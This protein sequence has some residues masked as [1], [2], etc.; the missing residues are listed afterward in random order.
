MK[1]RRIVVTGMGVVS[2]FGND[3]DSFYNDLLDGKSGVKKITEFD[4]EE[5]CCDLCTC[6]VG[7]VSTKPGLTMNNQ[8]E[9]GQYIAL[10]GLVPVK[11]IGPIKKSDFIVPTAN[12]LARAGKPEE[13]AHKIGV[14]NETNDSDDV[15]LVKCIIK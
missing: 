3:V 7:V 10:T 11:V 2:A 5:S 1:K 8:Q 6:V 12:G 4:V 9:E 13:I 14:C 15:K